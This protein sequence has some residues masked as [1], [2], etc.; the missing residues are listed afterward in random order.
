MVYVFDATASLKYGR[1]WGATKSETATGIALD[2][3]ETNFYVSGYSD[4]IGQLSSIGI[5]MF[6]V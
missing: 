4:S 2:T 5:D 6:I 1:Y 3:A